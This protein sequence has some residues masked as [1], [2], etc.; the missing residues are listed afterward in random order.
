MAKAFFHMVGLV[1]IPEE[2]MQADRAEVISSPGQRINSLLV[3]F[4]EG[5]ITCCSS[6]IRDLVLLTWEKRSWL[7]LHTRMELIPV[8]MLTQGQLIMSLE[9]LRN[10]P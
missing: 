5:P 7:I 3:S 10:L 1:I 2:A 6:V 8:G 4:V 9:S